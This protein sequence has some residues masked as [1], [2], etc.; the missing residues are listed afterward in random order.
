MKHLEKYCKE[1]GF[2]ANHDSEMQFTD[3][4]E[5]D[6]SA[7]QTSLAGPTRP[8]DKCTL[9]SLRDSLILKFPECTDAL[10]QLDK[11]IL[12]NGDIVLAA[13]TSCT[14]TSNPSVLIAAGLL[15]KK[16]VENG[17][18]VSKKVKTSLAPGSRVVKDYLEKSGLQYYLDKLGFN[19][20]GYAG[21]A[22]CTTLN[23]CSR[24]E[25]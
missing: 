22:V 2:W 12:K 9:S 19:I 1:H 3:I 25:Q 17:L 18:S 13:I 8:Q 14:N 23:Q 24:Q 6:L 16:A 7:V 15:A 10:N 4:V 21:C 20:V 11:D 5:I